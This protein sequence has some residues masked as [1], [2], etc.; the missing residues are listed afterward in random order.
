L[1]ELLLEVLSSTL[2]LLKVWN[3]TSSGSM[4]GVPR[5]YPLYLSGEP[6]VH[7]DL[8]VVVDLLH[9]VPEPTINLS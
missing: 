5:W 6:G 8:L 9:G 1:E 2:A 7:Q 3:I 4:K